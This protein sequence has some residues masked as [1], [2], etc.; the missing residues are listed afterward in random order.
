MDLDTYPDI[1]G[2]APGHGRT[3]LR[4]R[5]YP[6]AAQCVYYTGSRAAAGACGVLARVCVCV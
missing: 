6:A 4:G 3:R 5:L 2:Y 1:L